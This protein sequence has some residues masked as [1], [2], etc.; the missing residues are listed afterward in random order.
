[1][2]RGVLTSYFVNGVEYGSYII[3]RSAADVNRKAIERGLGEKIISQFMPVKTLV[4]YSKLKTE[5]LLE[6]LPEVA[7]AVCFVSLPA[8][9]TG[10][11][12]QAEILSDSG[13]LHELIHLMDKSQ[14]PD[15]V[16]LKQVRRLLR[17]LESA[18]TGFY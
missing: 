13:L 7:H 8:I 1:M 5:E 17:R 6:R 3:G 16:V 9:N 12:T 2:R 4:S 10:V 18:A 15:P 11:L 14:T